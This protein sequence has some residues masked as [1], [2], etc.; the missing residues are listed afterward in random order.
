M[1][2]WSDDGNVIRIDGLSDYEEADQID[3]GRLVERSNTDKS[4]VTN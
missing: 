2:V 4:M 1:M 3:R